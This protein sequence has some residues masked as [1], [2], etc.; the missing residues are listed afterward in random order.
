M[1]S[2]LEERIITLPRCNIL[3]QLD[4][5][6]AHL[7]TLGEPQRLPDNALRTV[8]NSFAGDSTRFG[9]PRRTLARYFRV[10]MQPIDNTVFKARILVNIMC[11]IR[12]SLQ[13]RIILT[14]FLDSDKVGAWRRN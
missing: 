2:F 8:R 6:H 10:K 1:R 9:L 3:V 5:N 14:R 7:P 13:E 12:H 4:P 11:L